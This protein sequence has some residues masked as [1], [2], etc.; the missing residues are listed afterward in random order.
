MA[1]GEKQVVLWAVSSCGLRKGLIKET[2]ALIRYL[3]RERGQ[4]GSEK[5]ARD[6]D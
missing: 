6:G 1:E 2:F 5:E 4:K 3:D